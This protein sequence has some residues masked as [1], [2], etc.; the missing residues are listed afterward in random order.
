MQDRTLSG[1]LPRRR[2]EHGVGPA[3]QHQQHYQQLD[4]QACIASVMILQKIEE[5][6]L[7]RPLVSSTFYITL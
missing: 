2:G 4:Q 1:N 5:Q 7:R 3:K 6:Q